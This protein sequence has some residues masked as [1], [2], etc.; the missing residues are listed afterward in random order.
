MTLSYHFARVVLPVPHLIQ[1]DKG[2]CLVACAAMVLG[3]AS[4]TYSY[5]KLTSLLATTRYGTVFSHLSNLSKAGFQFAVDQGGFTELHS[6]LLQ[7]RPVIIAVQTGELPYWR[8]LQILE[9]VPHAVVLVGLDNET[10]FV[11]DPAF[12]EAPFALPIS[13][14]DLARIEHDER[15]AFL[16]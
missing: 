8:D 10:A 15:Y 13:E 16:K 5:R 7:N 2:D 11:N 6:L 12:E 14:L 4:I 9:D 3:Y 1:H